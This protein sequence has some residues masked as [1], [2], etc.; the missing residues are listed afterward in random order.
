MS[1]CALCVSDLGVSREVRKK[2]VFTEFI[3]VDYWIGYFWTRHR[4]GD[5]VISLEEEDNWANEMSIVAYFFVPIVYFFFRL[6][7]FLGILYFKHRKKQCNFFRSLSRLRTKKTQ[8][9][10]NL[11]WIA[12]I[13]HVSIHVLFSACL[14][15]GGD[16]RTKKHNN[17]TIIVD[18]RTESISS[19]NARLFGYFLV[20]DTSSY[21]NNANDKKK[22]IYTRSTVCSGEWKWI[23]H[24][25]HCW[26]FFIVVSLCV[27]CLQIQNIIE[28][29]YDLNAWTDF[30]I[31]SFL[32]T[33]SPLPMRFA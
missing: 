29:N 12:A 13:L 14:L 1:M 28:A 5:W 31:C 9:P 4:C 18:H 2:V 23:Q 20:N 21:E 8:W 27:F 10:W 3:P 33:F 6:G 22:L 19:L 32:F 25:V 16:N 11:S 7:H 30:C 15:F 26:F 24:H 17:D